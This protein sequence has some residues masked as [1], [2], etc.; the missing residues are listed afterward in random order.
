MATIST[1]TSATYW[2]INSDNETAGQQYKLRA[3]PPMPTSDAG[4]VLHTFMAELSDVVTQTCTT[5]LPAST[6]FRGQG[7]S[8]I[9][10]NFSRLN[11]KGGQ[12]F[13]GRIVTDLNYVDEGETITYV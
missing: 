12:H 3:G 2:S 6:S 13:Q 5:S 7:G 1:S 4:F 9:S 11:V 8:Y 10:A